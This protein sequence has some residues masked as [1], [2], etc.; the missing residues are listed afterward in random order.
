[1]KI[2]IIDN[3]LCFFP[4]FADKK[5]KMCVIFKI[6]PTVQSVALDHL[7]FLKMLKN[8]KTFL[9]FCFFK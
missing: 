3:I 6:F 7:L 5:P 4:Y 1:M 9:M 2:L 8:L